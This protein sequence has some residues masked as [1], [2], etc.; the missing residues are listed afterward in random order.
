M[1]TG[2]IVLEGN[3]T[4]LA[5]HPLVKRAYLGRRDEEEADPSPAA[6]PPSV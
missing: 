6:G 4:D 1:E 5:H 2:E 3:A